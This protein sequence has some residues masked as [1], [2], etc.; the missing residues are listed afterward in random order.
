MKNKKSVE[1]TDFFCI[2]Y[3]PNKDLVIFIIKSNYNIMGRQKYDTQTL[4][5][6]IKKLHGDKYIL[7]KV[8]Y[9]GYKEK[10]TLI[11]PEHGEFEIGIG[12]LLSGQG[13]PKCRYVKSAN[14]KRRS[15]EDVIKSAV[16]IHGDKYDYS[17]IKDYKN[18]RVKYPI[19]CK[20]HDVIFY[21]TFNNH[22][23]GKQGCPICGREKSNSERKMTFEEY[24]EIA[25]NIH[26]GYYKYLPDGFNGTNGKITYICPKHG[27]VIQ[28]AS[29]HIHLGHNCPECNPT[30]STPENELYEFLSSIVGKDNIEK[31]NRTILNNK[32]ELDLYIPSKKIAIELDGLYWHCEINKNKNYHLNKTIECDK[33]GIH[34]IHVFED[35]WIYKQDI[36]KSMLLNQL[37]NTENKIYARN[38]EIRNVKPNESR[39]FL[40]HNHLQGNCNSKIKLGLYYNGELVSLMTF[41]QSR[42]FIGNKEPKWEL[43]RF[44]NKLN[45][46]VIGGASKLF[47]YFI[48]EYNPENVVSYADRRWSNGKLYDKL[49]FIKY[50]ESKPNY[51]YV[52]ENKRV[53]RFN[54][55]KRVLVE[56]YG[57][58]EHMTEKEFCKQKKWYRIYDC[59]CLCHIWK[60][61]KQN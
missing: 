47:N 39:I 25:N 57:C 58:P 4:K 44:C 17:L 10:I 29:N 20:K 45:T 32:H 34:L 7:D 35:E 53:Y 48:K 54:L 12:H 31:R 49:G 59:G 52:I 40:N 43:Q 55:R 16:E 41:G 51:F 9:R 21:Q 50:N 1:K 8:T 2:L 46:N 19:R 5:E 3:V 13:C 56:K 60:N 30:H 22:I 23:K 6:A 24:V 37:G 61:N 26:N 15:L 42:H 36:I 27:I 11:C 33:K 28:D 38:C 14:R 18:D